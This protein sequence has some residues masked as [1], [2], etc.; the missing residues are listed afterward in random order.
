VHSPFLCAPALNHCL[1]KPMVGC[2]GRRAGVFCA[3]G[4]EIILGKTAELP[5]GLEALRYSQH[6]Q[7]RR[8]IR[9]SP[10]SAFGPFL[11][12]THPPYGW[13]DVG[14]VCSARVGSKSS[15]TPP[16]NYP[17]DWERL[18]T[19]TFP[20]QAGNPASAIMSIRAFFAPDTPALRLAGCRAGVF[21][22][23]GIEITPDTTAE[24]PA[25]LGTPGHPNI[26][27]LGG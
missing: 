11:R 14:R 17:P 26:P 18:A 1:L 12:R 24:L 22:V 15:L 27:Q 20:N 4:I 10:P 9:R 8:V 23:S 2:Q 19:P 16:Q 6:F 21:C 5:A 3:S 25:G 7:T 13:P